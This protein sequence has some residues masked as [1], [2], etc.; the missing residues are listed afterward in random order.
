MRAALGQVLDD[1]EEMAHGTGQP[2]Q[3]HDDEDVAG[4]DLAEQPGEG[5]AGSRGARAVLGHDL[6]AAGGAQ[7][8]RLRVGLLLLGRDAGIA[9]QTA[10]GRRLR[11]AG[12]RA[13]GDLGRA[14]HVWT[15]ILG[16]KSALAT[17]LSK[18]RS[19]E[20]TIV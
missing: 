9:D 20:E 8:L 6:D 17:V 12:R 18:Y 7:L 5:R 15:S 11:S 16:A 19:Y 4:A 1:R 3:P 2:V 10:A 13:V 14:A